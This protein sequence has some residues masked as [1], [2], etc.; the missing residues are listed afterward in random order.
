MITA[1]GEVALWVALL[2]AG[3]GATLG[4]VGGSRGRGDLVL[5]AERSTYA[6]FGLL[7]VSCGAIIA[8][9]MFYEY[10]YQYVT[11]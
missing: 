1:I 6:V 8:S 5:S 2:L 9:F 11:G 4:F 3:W 7:V 10:V